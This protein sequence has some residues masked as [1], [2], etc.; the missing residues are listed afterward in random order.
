MKVLF[1]TSIT[2]SASHRNLNHFQHVHHL[3]RTTDFAI[4]GARGSVFAAARAGT[5]VFRSRFSGKLGIVLLALRFALSGRARDYDIVLTDP[6]LLGFLGWLLK[7]AGTRRW[8]VDAWDIPG[9][10]AMGKHWL[11]G[12]RRSTARWFLRSIYRSAD[13]FVV[14]ILPEFEF[15]AFRIPES[16]LLRCKNAI[17]LD[18]ML[19]LPPPSDNAAPTILCMRSVHTA[20]MGLDTLAAAYVQVAEDLDGVSL[21]LIGRIPEH[22]EA[23]AA[24]LRCRADVTHIERLEHDALQR[25][26]AAATVCV[27][28][29][30]D[31]DDLRQTYPVKI[32][33]YMAL[34]KPIV[35]S[36][37]AG[38]SRM[39][40]D[41]KTGLLFRPGDPADLA[42]KLRLVCGDPALRRRLSEN[43]RQ[44]VQGF[45][46]NAKN[47]A[48][49]NA[50][51]NLL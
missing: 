13:L 21:V 50:M 42:E 20:P 9:R 41:G 1:V 38:M 44:A 31:V 47:E 48:I 25:A 32:L 35:A 22:V 30:H 40:E 29:F 49:R 8:V 16:K 2:Q 3:S 18:D 19:D 46:C 24:A 17:W 10:Y 36:G 43:A 7:R 39:I 14:S 37:I 23:Q 6:S 15:R 26:I 27:V 28:P 11:N 45:D 4:L 12:V 33:E 51:E 34:G 5:P